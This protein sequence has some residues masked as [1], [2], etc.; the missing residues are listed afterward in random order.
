MVDSLEM[1]DLEDESRKDDNEFESDLIDLDK[2]KEQDK[3]N[4]PSFTEKAADLFV[5]GGKGVLRA[6]TWPLDILKLGMIG[7][8]LAGADE[9]EELYFKAG[10][11]D[12]FDRDAY[13]K[14][15]LETSEFIPTQDFAEKQLEKGTGFSLKP[16]SELGNLVDQG[17]TIAT[18]SPGGALKKG[19]SALTA[20]A[21]TGTLKS[22][23]VGDEKAELAGDLTSLG[24][25]FIK[26]VPR[27]LSKEAKNLE[28]TAQKHVL[29]FLEMMTRENAPRVKGKISEATS[30][31]LKNE[32]K[33]STEE[34]IN[35]V[36]R[37]EFMLKR[38]Q[39]N[40][41]NLEDLARHAYDQTERLAARNP[42][43]FNTTPMVNN[44]EAEINRIKKL[45]PSPSE[46]QKT[47]I[48]LL[49]NQR[50]AMKVASPNS[51]QLVQQHK[52]YNADMKSIYK[53]PEFSGKQEEIRKSYEFLKK[54]T[55]DLMKN[56]G[57]QATAHSFEAANKIF[58]QKSML[59]E[60]QKILEKGFKNGEYSP[61]KLQS[62]LEGRDSKFLK[63]NMSPSAI[64][65]I[66]D[67]AK[68]GVEAEKKMSQFIQIADPNV[69]NSIASWGQLAP[70]LFLPSKAK[71]A[72]LAIAKSLS[73]RTQGKLL[74]SDATRNIYKATLK[75]AAEGSFQLLKKDF[76]LLEQAI[77]KEYG[78][79]DNFI[80]KMMEEL[81]FLDF[82]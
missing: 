23:G 24:P 59:E 82:D 4:E 1:I 67:I 18:L 22:L 20:M 63:R 62:V 39:E 46:A 8:G 60:T 32:F 10:K 6:F 58:H 3:K 26:K 12:E 44:I 54:Q 81:E 36:Q 55:V 52:N 33:L 43:V 68:Y 53:K 45:A 64:Q 73:E 57:N 66:K 42:K 61:K 2:A 72:A 17:A 37:N 25:Q 69:I 14:D 11:A 71:G 13:I 76:H 15:V 34:A 28:Q 48:E 27:M 29:P 30:K 70:L 21:T 31:N 51:Q 79:V 40:G 56:Q 49:E 7:E 9:L 50:D 16:K 65:D 75:H 80:D 77:S 19:A 35:K 78:D 5:Q 74:T 41:V 47:A 38:M